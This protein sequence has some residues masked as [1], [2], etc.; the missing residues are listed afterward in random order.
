MGKKEFFDMQLYSFTY[1]KYVR[2][3][4]GTA[5]DSQEAINKPND[6]IFT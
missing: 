1:E 2:G 4:R 6:N 5:R 3:Q